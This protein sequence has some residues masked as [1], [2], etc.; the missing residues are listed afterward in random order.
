[1]RAG[2]HAVKLVIPRR[3]AANFRTMIGMID[4]RTELKPAPEASAGD[5]M[6][7]LQVLNVVV[8]GEVADLESGYVTDGTP[9]VLRTYLILEITVMAAKIAYENAAFVENVVNNV[10][11]VIN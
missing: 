7:Q 1:M 8:S 9:L 10:W 3:D 5:D 6:R 2:R 11:K 4:G